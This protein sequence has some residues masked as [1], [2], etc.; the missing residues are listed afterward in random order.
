MLL[1]WREKKPFYT[2]AKA[3]KDFISY[4]AEWKFSE[5]MGVIE[6]AKQLTDV[7]KDLETGKRKEV[8]LSHLALEAIYY[9][10]SKETGKGLESAQ[11]YFNLLKPVTDALSRAKMDKDKKDQMVKDLGTVQDAIER[12]AVSEMEESM[13]LEIEAETK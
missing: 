11:F 4:K 6:T 5:S 10:M 7:I 9:F 1:S 13:L 3:L 12:G 8:M 2:V